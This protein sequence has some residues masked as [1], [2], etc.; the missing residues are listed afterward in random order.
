MLCN[1]L[2]IACYLVILAPRA[3]KQHVKLLVRVLRERHIKC[4]AVL[5]CNRLEKRSVPALLV[6]RLKAVYLYSP[7]GKRQRLV[8]YHLFRRYSSHL[9]ES[10]TFLARTERIVKREHSRRQLTN[11]YSVFLA[12]IALRER[13]FR[14]TLKLFTVAKYYGNDKISVCQRKRGFN[15]VRKSRAHILAAHESVDDYLNG[16]L[17]VLVELYFLAKVVHRAVHAY[18]H[19]TALFRILEYLL[20]HTLFAAYHRREHHK[21][22]TL[23]KHHYA[24]DYLI[25]GL[26]TYLLTAYGTVRYTDASVKQT[27][28]VVYLRDRS[29]GRA[30]IF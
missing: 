28:V 9:A 14:V 5:L 4:E 3:V 19:V 22:R 12:G 23:G 20:V 6:K 24:V 1:T 2:P 21:A 8:G 30:R 16:V 17:D 26:L 29:D 25:D 15:R 18:T 27:K 7:L 10:R 13:H 11:T